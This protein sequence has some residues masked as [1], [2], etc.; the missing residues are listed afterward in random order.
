MAR[1]LASTGNITSGSVTAWGTG[2]DVDVDATLGDITGLT[3]EANDVADVDAAG[4]ELGAA[5]A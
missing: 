2:S 4:G 5:V 3:V 1:V